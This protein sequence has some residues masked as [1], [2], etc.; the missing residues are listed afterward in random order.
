MT[1]HILILARDP[2]TR[3]AVRSALTDPSYDVKETD[4]VP[5]ALAHVQENRP[6]IIIADVSVPGGIGFFLQR[7]KALPD[8]PAVLLIADMATRQQAADALQA[9]AVDYMLKPILPAEVGVRVRRVMEQKQASEDIHLQLVQ[10]ETMVSLGRLVAGVAHEVNTPVGAIHSNSDVMS[11]VVKKLRAAIESSE[12]GNKKGEILESL[13]VLSTLAEVST[14][15]SQRIAESVRNLKTFARLDE[16]QR[17][18]V[19]LH[20]GLDS[21]VRLVQCDFRDRIRIEKDYGTI[22]P[23][24]CHPHQLN[25]VFMNLLVNAADA[26]DGR[27]I[28]RIS[29]RLENQDVVIR[30]SDSGRG[31]SPEHLRKIFQPGF[32]TKGVGVG[33]GLGLSLACRI[34]QAH[35]G[36]ITAR[37][38]VGQGTTFTVTLPVPNLQEG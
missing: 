33:M 31:I 19:D 22:P 30:V 16:S 15:A 4:V 17:Q 20:E 29:T 25:Q 28:I 32:T 7:V 18:A 8:P 12:N 21:T 23:I 11:R 24:E 6:Q 3:E 1:S 27:G 35:A 14:L 2:A 5:T 37:S 34:V 13:Q 26:I 38:T 9:G 36:T 10:A